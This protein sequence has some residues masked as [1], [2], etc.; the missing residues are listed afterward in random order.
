MEPVRVMPKRAPSR[1]ATARVSSKSLA[2]FAGE[3]GLLRAC[4]GYSDTPLEREQEPRH[5]AA[6]YRIIGVFAGEAGLLG[7]CTGY[8]DTLP[9]VDK[10]GD[11]ARVLPSFL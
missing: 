8:S 11:R 6:L 2:F 9:A 10:F 3:A 4:S 1:R 5:A 7:A